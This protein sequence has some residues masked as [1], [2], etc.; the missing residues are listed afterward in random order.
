MLSWI[1][2]VWPLVSH[3]TEGTLVIAGLLAAAWFSP[4]FKKEFLYSAIAVALCLFVYAIGVHDEKVKRDAAE[5]RTHQA[6][7]DAVDKARHPRK[8]QKD[9][10]DDP[11]N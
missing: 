1:A 4:V 6:I 8:K 10:F 9:P 5:A 11:R 2:G 7:D 3:V